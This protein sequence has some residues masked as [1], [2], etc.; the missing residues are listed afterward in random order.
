M[1]CL[2][3]I[4]L[5]II[6]LLWIMFIWFELLINCSRLDIFRILLYKCWILFNNVL[7]VVFYLLCKFVIFVLMLI[8]FDISLFMVLVVILLVYVNWDFKV[9]IFFFCFWIWYFSFKKF[10]VRIEMEIYFFRG[11]GVLFILLKINVECWV[12]MYRKNNWN[13][14]RK[15]MLKMELLL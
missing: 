15:V 9:V 7:F 4:K 11:F 2:K 10:W 3:E 8:Y 6:Y 1:V 12:I 14:V 13:I 5:V